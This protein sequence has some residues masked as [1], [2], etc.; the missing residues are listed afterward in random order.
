MFHLQSASP[1]LCQLL[2][3][4]QLSH[5]E[6]RGLLGNGV[7][8]CLQ[9]KELQAARARG[10]ESTWVGSTEGREPGLYDCGGPTPQRC[11]CDTT[12]IQTQS[13]IKRP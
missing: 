10:E 11:T 2:V 4:T 7:F 8:V 1:G 3:Y 12:T 5:L 13:L 6:L 9:A